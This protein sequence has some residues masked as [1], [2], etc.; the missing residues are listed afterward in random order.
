MA[1]G[2]KRI[3]LL[4]GIAVGVGLLIGLAAADVASAQFYREAR[5]PKQVHTIVQRLSNELREARH[6]ESATR[7]YSAHDY[8]DFCGTYVT[9]QQRRDV[10]RWVWLARQTGWKWSEIDWLMHHIARESRGN[11][12]A[13][14]P[15]STASGLLQFLAFHWD[16]SGK[17]QFDPYNP[18]AAL[19]YGHKLYLLTNGAAWVV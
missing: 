9:V 16:G 18:R 4:V 10:G 14:N 15:S 2:T 12:R 5:E 17:W 19:Y 13:K 1:Y 8:S 3:I 7:Y 11:P 6:V